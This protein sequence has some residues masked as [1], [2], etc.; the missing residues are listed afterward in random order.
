MSKLGITEAF[1]KYGAKLNNPQWS[2]S[3]WAVDGSLVVS[4]WDHHCRKGRPGTMEFSDSMSRWSGHGNT[5]F[6]RNV[7]DAFQ[8]RSRVRLVIAKT[9]E[10]TYVDSGKGASLVKKEFF[11][12]EDLIGEVAELNGDNFVFCFRKL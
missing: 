1:A 9:S 11:T 5:E 6:K 3:A 4:L 12:R 8:K 10:T 2:V 7:V